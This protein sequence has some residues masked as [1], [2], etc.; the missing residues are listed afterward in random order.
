LRLV[1][2][3]DWHI[4]KRFLETDML[5][6][7]SAFCDWLVDLVT[8]ERIDCVLVA[9]DVYDRANPKDEAVELLDDVLYRLNHAGASIVLISGNH[10]SADRLHFGTRFMAGS[11][12]HIRTER[13]DIDHIGAPV[14]IVG[15][16]GTEVEILPLPYLDPERVATMA[17]T[18]RSHE[19]VLRAVVDRRVASLKDPSRTI[20]MAHAFVAGGTS[21]ESERALSIGGSSSVP[22]DLFEPFGYVAL[23]HLHRPQEFADGRVAYSG[24]PMPY[25]FSEDHPKSIRILDVESAGIRSS[26]VPCPAG[27]PVITLTGTLE[28]LLESS[29]F[30]RHVGSFVR[31]RLEGDFRVGAM[32]RLRSRFPH[33]LELEQTALTRQGLLDSERLKHMA[34]RSQEEVVRQYVDETWPDGLDDFCR[35]LIDDA[36]APTISGDDQ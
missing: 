10:D 36:L 34:K 1:H 3:S 4:G 15:R 2:T 23:G 16:D 24:T 18:T 6:L 28:Q 32:D 7:Q 8:S 17:G 11:G 9:G 35:S 21:S 29:Q 14:T 5:P 19:A 27:R 13:R 33:V 12:L 31:A 26:V 22:I 30:E 20:A 25:S